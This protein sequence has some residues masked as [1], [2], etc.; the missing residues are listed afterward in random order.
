MPFRNAHYILLLLVPMIALAFWPSYFGQVRSAPFALHAHGL[1]AMAWLGLLWLQAWTAHRRLSLHRLSGLAIFVLAPLFVMGGLLAMQSM[2][3]LAAA[4]SDPFHAHYGARLALDDALAIVAFLAL[5]TFA[6]ARRRSVW[7]HGG[8]MLATAL[9]VLPPIITRLP[10]FP[11]GASF[12]TI[13]LIAQG[14]ALV[15]AVVLAPRRPGPFRFVGATIAAQIFLV[16]TF[17]LSAA[18]E[19]I[20]FALISV[21]PIALAIAGLVLGAVP[22]WLAWRRPAGSRPAAMAA[23]EA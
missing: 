15:G 2:A 5:V 20:C 17:G 14:T 12:S 16:Q 21:P 6:V 13:F 1:S 19:R 7:M 18:W 4:K 10:V 9:L 22:L 3:T 11:E 8:A 23:A